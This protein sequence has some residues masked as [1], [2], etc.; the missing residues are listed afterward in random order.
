MKTVKLILGLLPIALIM[1]TGCARLPTMVDNFHG[2]SYEL[3]KRSQLD[4][5]RAGN[6]PQTI[7]G[8]EG[9]VGQKIMNRYEA[10]FQTPAPKTES[11]SITVGGMTKK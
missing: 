2:T 1:M 10:G 8:M 11:Y 7:T 9:T 5:P 6:V 4:N 3:A